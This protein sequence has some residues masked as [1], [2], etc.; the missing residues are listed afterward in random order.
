MF[1]GANLFKFNGLELGLK[2]AG[3]LLG[4]PAKEQL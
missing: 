2:K 4:Y 3:Y 1:C